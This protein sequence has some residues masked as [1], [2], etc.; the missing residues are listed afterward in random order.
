MRASAAG[1]RARARDV[2]SSSNQRRA[3]GT[4]AD[5]ANS[6]QGALEGLGLT[7]PALALLD[8]YLETLERWSR[9]LNLTALDTPAARVDRLVR[10]AARIAPELDPGRLA[11]IGSGN[12]APGIVLAILR[13]DLPVTLLEP[14][15]RRAVFLEEV[16]SE[17]RLQNVSVLRSRHDGWAGEPFETLTLKALE[18]PLEELAPMLR[19]G[20]AIW[21]F[22]GRPKTAKPFELEQT[23]EVGGSA[24]RLFR[25][26]PR[27]TMA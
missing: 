9:R 3:A 19:P 13:P 16:Y 22:G 24:L 15:V 1:A 4:T 21:R 5:E 26:V 7:G 12:G 10:D 27:G 20:G 14:R 11:D 2:A 17:L 25:H 8:R 23:V 6:H 18:L